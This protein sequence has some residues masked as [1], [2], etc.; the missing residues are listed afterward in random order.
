MG[1][2][3]KAMF[4]DLTAVNPSWVCFPELADEFDGGLINLV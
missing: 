1:E 4:E 3:Y 2:G